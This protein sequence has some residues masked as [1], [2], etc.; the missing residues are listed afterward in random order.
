MELFGQDASE[1]WWTAGMQPAAAPHHVVGGSL[2]I[3]ALGGRYHHTLDMRVFAL[4]GG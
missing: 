1:C 3:D 4:F 2:A